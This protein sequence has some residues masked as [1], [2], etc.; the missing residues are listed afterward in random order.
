MDSGSARAVTVAEMSPPSRNFKRS[1]WLTILSK[2]GQMPLRLVRPARRVYKRDNFIRIHRVVVRG[3][4]P[5]ML[6]C[7]V[8]N[9][10]DLAAVAEGDIADKAAEHVESIVRQVDSCGDLA[11][12]H[13]WLILHEHFSG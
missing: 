3:Q 2:R 8:S 11:L 4:S 9:A 5:A 12:D 7:Q 10:D 1:N 13:L 6:G